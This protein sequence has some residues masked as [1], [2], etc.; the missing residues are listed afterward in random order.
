VKRVL[1][2]VYR[3][4]DG[5]KGVRSL[6]FLVTDRVGDEI[7]FS[8]RIMV[9]HKFKETVKTNLSC[10]LGTLLSENKYAIDPAEGSSLEKYVAW[11]PDKKKEEKKVF[12]LLQ[13]LA[14]RWIYPV[15]RLPLTML[16]DSAR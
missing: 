3:F 9:E 6:H 8:F 14:K 4:A 10:K 11:L 7:I 5:L 15:L 2:E 1:V 16:N 12:L 13:N